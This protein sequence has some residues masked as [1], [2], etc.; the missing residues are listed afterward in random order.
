MKFFFSVFR[1]AEC[2]RFDRADGQVVQCGR[3]SQ[4]STGLTFNIQQ[5]LIVKALKH[6]RLDN[7]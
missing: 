1:L 4:P 6:L 2:R 7:I 3:S 5:H